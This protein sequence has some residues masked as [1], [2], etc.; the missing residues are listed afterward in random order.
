MLTETW[1]TRLCPLE[2]NQQDLQNVHLKFIFRSFYF[3]FFF[4]YEISPLLWELLNVNLLYFFNVPISFFS[5]TPVSI[6]FIEL[7]LFYRVFRNNTLGSFC[8]EL[9]S[10]DQ[11]ASLE[12]RSTRFPIW[13][14][15][16]QSSEHTATCNSSYRG[17][18]T[19]FWP[20]RAM[21]A[22]VVHIYM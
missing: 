4:W 10:W 20:L 6:A 21:N 14:R 9:N 5:T 15:W 7:S 11:W 22:H 16:I 12:V 17:I 1:W 18:H 8:L 13:K 19:F 3:A 2:S